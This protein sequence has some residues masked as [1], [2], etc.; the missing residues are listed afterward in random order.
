[1]TSYFK[2]NAKDEKEPD[3]Q[4]EYVE[5]CISS[6]LDNFI[7]ARTSRRKFIVD[8]IYNSIQEVQIQP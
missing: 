2:S 8:N 7:A 3:F 4:I 5:T 6:D 1:M